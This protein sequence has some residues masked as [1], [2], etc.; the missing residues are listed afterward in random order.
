MINA[1]TFTQF[2]S[3]AS[4]FLSLVFFQRLLTRCFLLGINALQ[5]SLLRSIRIEHD[6][7]ST[8]LT[9]CNQVK[10]FYVGVDDPAATI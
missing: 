6:D 3:L 8:P 9:F 5:E 7:Q 1:G 10:V 2:F 4:L